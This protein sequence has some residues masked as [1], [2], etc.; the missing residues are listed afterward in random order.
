MVIDELAENH[1]IDVETKLFDALV[2]FGDIDGSDCLL[3]KPQ[4]YM[5]LSGDA[6]LSI[7]NKEK[8]SIE[9]ILIVH[10]ELDLQF[11]TLKL[12]KGGSSGGHNGLKSIIENLNGNQNFLRLRVGIS[13]DK[14][15]ADYVLSEFKE[16]E[17]LILNEVIE[18]S[19]QAVIA[20]L[21][22][23][24]GNAMNKFN[25]TNLNKKEDSVIE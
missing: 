12:K 15:V 14:N 24:V 22:M 18:T 19:A 23:G 2:G 10:D 16:E 9:E 8:I 7:M 3:M 21:S 13:R 20:C 17:K 5:N 11:G 6:I 1:G 4:T 25:S